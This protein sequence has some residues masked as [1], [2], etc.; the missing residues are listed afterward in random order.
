MNIDAGI[1]IP[2]LRAI[3]R[4]RAKVVV[5]LAGFVLLAV[6]WLSMALANQYESY[7]TI[8]VEPQS[9]SPE[10]VQSGVRQSDLTERLHLMTA[11]ILSRPRLSRMIDQFELYKE[12]S[13]GMT[14][15]EVIDL[16]R[17][18]VRV[19]PVLPEMAASTSLRQAR[20]AQITQFRIFFFHP[21]GKQAR[22]VA[23]RLANDFIEE[24][25]NERVKISQKSLEFIGGELERISQRMVEIE[26]E[27]AKVKAENPG[28]LPEDASASQ[29]R[30]ERLSDAISRAQRDYDTA[31]SDEAFW[32]SQFVSIGAL[33]GGS[34]DTS[35]FRRV[36]MLELQIAEYHARGFTEKHP[37]YIKAKLEMEGLRE[38]I[39]SR[40]LEEEQVEA[41][42]NF[43]QQTAEAE[44]N[45]AELKM[46]SAQEEIDRLQVSAEQYQTLL[47]ETPRV[48]ERLDGLG[49]EYKS[50]LDSYQTYI[51]RRQQAGVQADME[52]RQLGEQFR[53]L[54]AAF[55]APEPSSPNRIVIIA[56]GAVFGLMAGLGIGFLLEAT[57]ASLHSGRQLQAA[58]SLPVLAAIPQILLESDRVAR[59]RR[60]FRQA[61]ASAGVS[62]FMLA[63]GAVTYG[64]VNG[65]P[66]FAKELLGIDE[67]A[68][69]VESAPPAGAGE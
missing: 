37:D 42:P 35:P 8:L 7:A 3:V 59:R 13:E 15:E 10:L 41:P 20:E 44:R 61:F 58:L 11:Q 40:E 38:A 53:V 49:R 39:A 29:R 4:R 64:W 1:Q 23:Q 21:D 9:I 65:M 52:R 45:R 34:D 36:Q 12:E 56:V 16:M 43:A 28:R 69:E 2:E 60:A 24:H 47:A 18:A 67:E 5:A 57:D 55:I 6:Y 63:G 31:R 46:A 51:V 33:G 17:A 62:L 30:L 14:R 68:S 50:Q 54:E 19:E 26:A 25:I 66:G 32:R 27:V 22:D 48:A